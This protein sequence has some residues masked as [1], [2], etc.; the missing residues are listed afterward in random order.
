M[1]SAALDRRSAS[2]RARAFSHNSFASGK[3]VTTGGSGRSGA[4]YMG[5]SMMSSEALAE[6]GRQGD[7]ETRR[8][9]ESQTIE[10]S[11]SLVRMFRFI[12]YMSPCLPVSLSPSH[13]LRPAQLPRPHGQQTQQ[14]NAGGA[15]DPPVGGQQFVSGE[16]RHVGGLQSRGHGAHGQGGFDRR[17]TEGSIASQPNQE[18]SN[19]N[20]Q[21]RQ[22]RSGGGCR[23][24]AEEGAG[25]GAEKQGK[26]RSQ[27]QADH[28]ALDL[29]N[30]LRL[31]RH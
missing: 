1:V 22:V 15:D 23:G 11:S 21:E 31:D 25:G 17:V 26:H 16:P 5:D 18:G 14:S 7:K 6:T 24:R 13:S 2:G 30:Q 3:P 12:A 8:Q 9:G 29:R 19:A 27:G 20:R 4:R 28:H 10:E